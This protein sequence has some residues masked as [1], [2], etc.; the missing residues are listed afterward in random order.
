MLSVEY[1]I[2]GGVMDGLLV[3]MKEGQKRQIRDVAIEMSN[4]ECR[5][6]SQAEV[7]R[8]GALMWCRAFEAMVE[9]EQ[10]KEGE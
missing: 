2:G 10:I 4:R 5:F 6:V 1:I 8:I 9:G 3:R 7:V